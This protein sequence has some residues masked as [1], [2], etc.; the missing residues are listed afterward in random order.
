[1]KH[2]NFDALRVL[3]AVSSS[4]GGA[5]LRRDPD[6]LPLADAM[7]HVGRMSRR[8]SRVKTQLPVLTDKELEH[9]LIG[10]F[11]GRTVLRPGLAVIVNPRGGDVGMTQP[12]LH[13]G[14]VGLVIKRVGRGGCP[15][16]VR[17]DRETQR[18]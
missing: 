7:R 4:H 15:Q 5:R 6:A 2:G 18:R 16:R 12:L 17:P 14:N 10:H 13:L 3:S 8:K 9:S 1:M 11:E